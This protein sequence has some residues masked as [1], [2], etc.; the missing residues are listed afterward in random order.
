MLVMVNDWD[1]TLSVPM[2]EAAPAEAAAVIFVVVA[3]GIV[4]PSAPAGTC[5]QLQF[6]SKLKLFVASVDAKI[7]PAAKTGAEENRTPPNTVARSANSKARLRFIH[8]ETNRIIQ[9][10]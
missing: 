3:V 2:T 6:A 7:Q 1:P 5:P 9:K 10:K 8:R 4:K